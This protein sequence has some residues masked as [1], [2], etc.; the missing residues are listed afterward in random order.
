MPAPP[1]MAHG[2][3]GAVLVTPHIAIEALVLA[4]GTTVIA[5]IYPA[6]KASRQAIVDALRFNR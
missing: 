2:Y 5:S 4:I 6:W 1:G 3:T